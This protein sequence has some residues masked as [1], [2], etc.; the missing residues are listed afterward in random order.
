MTMATTPYKPVNSSAKT[1]SDSP[2]NQSS[3]FNG[4]SYQSVAFISSQSE[5]DLIRKRT[6]LSTNRS[7][8]RLTKGLLESSQTGPPTVKKAPPEASVLLRQMSQPLA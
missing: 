4:D 8:N 1:I 5:T 7:G 6:P 2:A 3:P